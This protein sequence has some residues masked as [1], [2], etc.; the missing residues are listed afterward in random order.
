MKKTNM[1][2]LKRMILITVIV[3]AMVLTC[4]CANDADEFGEQVVQIGDDTPSNTG[5]AAD[6]GPKQ[7]PAI[8]ENLDVPNGGMDIGNGLTIEK[9]IS[10]AGLYVEDGTDETVSGVLG[11]QV[12][13]NGDKAVQYAH[14]ELSN[15][16]NK[17]EFDLTTLP[18]GATVQLLE[19][20][21]RPMPESTDGY[22]ALVT[23]YAA[24][25][26][27]PG[28]NADALEITTQDTAITVKNI[29]GK[30]MGQVYV[31]YKVA[32]GELYLGGITYRV[33]VNG[34]AAGQS[35]TCYA[36]HYSTEYSKLMFATYEH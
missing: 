6:E 4:A 35:T 13:N 16:E 2:S 14:I 3:C 21:R 20:S 22:T 11:I 28:M 19:L 18:V 9:Y 32:Y 23:M 27:E 1:L 30:D 26:T 24:F 12:K 15:A 8:T 25:D 5:A 29:S 31:Y 36:G 10:Y 7:T 34:L 17:Y 33:S